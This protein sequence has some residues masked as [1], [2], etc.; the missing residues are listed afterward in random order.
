MISL[1]VC[2]QTKPWVTRHQWCVWFTSRTSHLGQDLKK[3]R[4]RVHGCNIDYTCD[5]QMYF[6]Y[7]WIVWNNIYVALIDWNVSNELS[8]K[9]TNVLEIFVN[10]LHVSLL[11]EMSVTLEISWAS[12]IVLGSMLRN[13]KDCLVM[14]DCLSLYTSGLRPIDVWI[15]DSN[16]F[17]KILLQYFSSVSDWAPMS[18]YRQFICL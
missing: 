13:L 12:I 17:L 7:H 11:F 18:W 2:A 10:K 4:F 14:Q 9:V 3:C 5:L 6:I 16:I 15:L 1:F 8:C